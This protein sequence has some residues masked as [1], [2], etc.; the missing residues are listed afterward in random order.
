MSKLNSKISAII[1][2]AL[3]SINSVDAKE[4]N[5]KK[6]NHDDSKTESFDNFNRK[7]MPVLKLDLNNPENNKF[8][9]SHVSHAS[10]RSHS[11]HRSHFSHRSGGMFA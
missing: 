6:V 1:G 11:S 5:I 2:A 3:A 4:L 9:A 10:H 7:P 8:I